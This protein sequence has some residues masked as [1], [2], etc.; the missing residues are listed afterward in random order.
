MER[1][2]RIYDCSVSV[3]VLCAAP[4]YRVQLAVGLSI[5]LLISLLIYFGIPATIGALKYCKRR[6][7]QLS[8]VRT[9]TQDTQ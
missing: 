9:S 7:A 6:T 5:G 1:I 4:I 8:N 2:V 3:F